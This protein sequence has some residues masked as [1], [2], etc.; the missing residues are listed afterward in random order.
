MSFFFYKPG[1]FFPNLL[2]DDANRLNFGL[3]SAA[4]APLYCALLPPNIKE[5]RGQL[6]WSDCSIMDIDSITTVKRPEIV[7]HE[8]VTHVRDY[9]KVY[10]IPRA[11]GAI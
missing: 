8:N 3:V 1:I 7:K 6:V 9:V 11:P 5:P 2:L 4:K 10:N